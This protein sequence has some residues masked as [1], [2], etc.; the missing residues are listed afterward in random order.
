[1]TSKFTLAL[2]AHDRKKGALSDFA[3]EHRNLLSRFHLVATKGTGTQIRTETRLPVYLLQ[4]GQAG[5]DTQMG[6]LAAENEVQAV[7][8]FR[9]PE[10]APHE[11]G[12]AD[13]LHLCEE[14]DILLATNPATAQAILYFLESSPERGAVV[15]SAWGLDRRVGV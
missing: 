1:L 9:D 11:P 12:F 3:F 14:R 7:I 8:F 13:L 2:I 5:G 6:Q 10:A 4:H 15:A